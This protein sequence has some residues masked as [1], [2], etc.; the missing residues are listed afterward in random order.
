[1]T[2]EQY[3]ELTALQQEIGLGQTRLEQLE[4]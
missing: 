1:M 2:Q 3:N 4:Q